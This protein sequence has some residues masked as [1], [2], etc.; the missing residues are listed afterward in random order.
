MVPALALVVAISSLLLSACTVAVT[1]G[2]GSMVSESR[3]VEAF[4]RIEADHG[5]DVAVSIGVA[6]DLRVQAHENLMQSISTTVEGNTLK[7]TA[8]R[9]LVATPRPLVT[10]VAPLLTTVAANSGSQIT[11]DELDSDSFGV[12]ISGGAVVTATG[13]ANLVALDASGGGQAQLQELQAGT[14]VVDVSGGATARIT[15]TD[16]ITG[17]VSG[18]A[19]AIVFGN[20]TVN[21]VPSG[22]GTVVRS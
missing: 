18:G 8:T 17:S 6:A 22:G 10:I 5:I 1:T 21:I 16:E 20:P 3:S 13:S 2:S 4:D 14:M 9:D 7:V 19:T 15:A 11:V 12:E